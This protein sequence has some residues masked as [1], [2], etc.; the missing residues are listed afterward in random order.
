MSTD[1]LPCEVCGQ[2]LKNVKQAWLADLLDGRRPRTLADH[3]FGAVVDSR[4]GRNY[5][6]PL[7]IG[8][9]ELDYDPEL[10]LEA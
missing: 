3:Q 10:P 9:I 8:V 5:Y 7:H 4:A 1:D 6:C 2:T